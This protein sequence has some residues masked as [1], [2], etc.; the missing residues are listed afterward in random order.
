LAF[1]LGFDPV[2]IIERVAVE[3]YEVRRF[4]WRHRY[5]R[6]H[7]EMA[8]VTP[9]LWVVDSHLHDSRI[10][11]GT[12]ARRFVR[13]IDHTMLDPERK[14]SPAALQDLQNADKEVLRGLE[15]E[16][17]MGWLRG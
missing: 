3:K 5:N 17:C 2:W 12:T 10:N 15:K 9:H 11:F 16:M 6:H 14:R 1:L 7:E 13:G 8:M 4:L